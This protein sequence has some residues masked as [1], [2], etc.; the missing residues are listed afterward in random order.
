MG[1][2]EE[3][4]FIPDP[5][6]RFSPTPFTW[7]VHKSTGTIQI[8]CNELGIALGLWKEWRNVHG[9]AAAR[10]LQH[11][12]L[13]VDRGIGYGGPAPVDQDALRKIEAGAVSM[14]LGEGGTVLFF[15]ATRKV[16]L[17][18]LSPHVTAEQ[19]LHQLL[20]R[21]IEL[22]MSVCSESLQPAMT[23]G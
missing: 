22:R 4:P 21:L 17:G 16:L 19:L 3:Q 12:R 1:L 20:P 14:L 23:K 11:V 7:A 15:D 9:E 13:V 8:E 5:L 6:M 10:S 2:I 18:F